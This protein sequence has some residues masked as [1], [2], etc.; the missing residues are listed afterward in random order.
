MRKTCLKKNDGQSKPPGSQ[1]KQKGKSVGA[2]RGW[3][4]KF[5]PPFRMFQ[6]AGWCADGIYHHLIGIGHPALQKLGLFQN[7]EA[8][9]SK[10]DY[11]H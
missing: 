4:S 6:L 10:K 5:P 9:I 11:L 1:T 3:G 2:Y 8:N 7:L